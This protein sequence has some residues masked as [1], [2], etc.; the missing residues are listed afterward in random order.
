MDGFIITPVA[1][2]HVYDSEVMKK[3]M[4]LQNRQRRQTFD[5]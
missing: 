1:C 3:I 4:K 5:I 2:G